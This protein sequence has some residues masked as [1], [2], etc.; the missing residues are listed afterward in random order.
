MIAPG[1]KVVSFR[2]YISTRRYH[3]G[4][5]SQAG[6]TFVAYALG[7]SNLP[8]AGSWRELRSYLRNGGAEQK[9]IAAANI[10]WRSYLSYLSK[11]RRVMRGMPA[12]R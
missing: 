11:E 3:Q 12:A 4:R 9:L 8:D 7:D 10:V 2:R 5:G 6:W 1:P